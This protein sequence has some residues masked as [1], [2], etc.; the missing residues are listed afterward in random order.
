MTLDYTQLKQLLMELVDKIRKNDEIRWDWCPGSRTSNCK[1]EDLR[2][3]KLLTHGPLHINKSIEICIC[4]EGHSYLQ[5]VDR[6]VVLEPGQFFVVMPRTLHNECIP[7]DEKCTDLWLNLRGDQLIRALVAGL[8]DDGEFGVLYCR[9]VCVEPSVKKLL[10]ETLEKE[11]DNDSFGAQILVKNRMVDAMIA[12]I[13]QLDM[14]DQGN[15]AKQ[16]QQSVVAEVMDYLHHHSTDRV[17]LQDLAD[18]M[19]IS[20]KHLNRIFK[21]ATGATIVNYA[22]TIRLE[23][24]KYYLTTTDLKIKDIAQLL[25]YYDQYHFGRI[26]KKATG[27]SPMEFRRAKRE[28]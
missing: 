26:F 15:T 3:K 13:R 10:S 7:A 18:H 27:R 9:A 5:L 1:M 11:L 8:D 25:N 21:S 20:V 19:A 14:E 22:N 6:V 16:W 17:E 2:G 28:E 24:A 4:V 12:M 23:Q